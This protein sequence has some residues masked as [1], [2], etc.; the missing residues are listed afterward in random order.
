[1]VVITQ[2]VEK[3][4]SV[5]ETSLVFDL[6]THLEWICLV[7]NIDAA[8]LHELYPASSVVHMQPL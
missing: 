1:M 6:C 2:N 4:T 3:E 5:Q 7:Q 8:S